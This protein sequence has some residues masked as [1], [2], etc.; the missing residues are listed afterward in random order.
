M[1]REDKEVKDKLV[2]EGILKRSLICTIALNDTGY[3]H[4]VPLNYGYSANT[5]WFHS[6]PEGRKIELLKRDGR[7]SFYIEDYHRIETAEVA[8]GW[9]TAYRSLAGTGTVEIITDE[10]G[11]RKGLDIL[12]AHNGAAGKM[13]YRE[14]QIGRM[15][16]LKLKIETIT[17]KQSGR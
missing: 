10:A 15:V 4:I 17:C 5:L 3:P 16:V 14:G 11:I 9:T 6:A 7:V 12:M 13:E 1:R 2:I 8:C